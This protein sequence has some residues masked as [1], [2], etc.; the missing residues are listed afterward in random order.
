MDERILLVE[1]KPDLRL[2]LKTALAR[3]GYRVSEAGDGDTAVRLFNEGDFGLV[4]TDLR[5]PGR[6][7]LELLKAVREESPETPVIV[8]T[9]YGTIEKAVEAMKDGAYDF[10]QKPIELAH[11]RQLVEHALLEQQL[12]R[13]NLLLREE[14]AERFGFPKIIGEHA[15]MKKVGA[16]LQRIAPSD[17]TVL[18]LG[19]SGTGKEL[20][21]RALHQ[22]SPRA[23]HPFVAINCAAIPESLVETELFGHEKGAFTGATDRKLGKFELAHHGTIFLDEIGE[24]PPGTQAKILRVLQERAFE[25]VG[26]VRTIQTD[27]RILAATNRDLEQAVRA[28]QFREDLYF[29]LAPFPIEIP[30]LRERGRDVLLLAQ[31][32]IPRFCREFKKPRLSLSASAEA[33]LQAYP[34]PGNVRELQNALERAVILAEG[35]SIEAEDL[36][37]RQPELPPPALPATLPLPQDF[38]WSGSL[39]EVS[40]R[41]ARLVER[42]RLLQAMQD[43]RWNKTRAA[44]RLKISYKTLL[45]KLHLYGLT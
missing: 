19:E 4:L 33:R 32:M 20:F 22:L 39:T 31:A 34:W 18:L 23:R 2:M 43:C 16:A 11:L 8:M 25:R 44:E 26:G 36:Q 10:I 9:A 37:L 24:L 12:Q 41:A 17:T 14:F 27:V 28:R 38:D 1:D 7:G 6:D 15:S 3:D 21:A 30:P 13:E 29:R 40:E 5:L 42:A 45:N 35:E